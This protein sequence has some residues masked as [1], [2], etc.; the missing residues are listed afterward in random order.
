ML[1]I[2]YSTGIEM[3]FA[4][5]VM[6]LA[7][8]P[9]AHYNILLQIN[10]EFQKGLMDFS[11]T[12]VPPCSVCAGFVL[13]LVVALC[14]CACVHVGKTSQVLRILECNAMLLLMVVYR[15]RTP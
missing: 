7:C 15:R 4:Q 1:V 6:K 2:E 9:D 3:S 14:D 11:N 8:L 10:E 5:V 13:D 12:K